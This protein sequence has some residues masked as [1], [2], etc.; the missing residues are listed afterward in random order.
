VICSR[1]NISHGCITQC[2]EALGY[3]SRFGLTIPFP[4]IV[5]RKP[6]AGGCGVCLLKKRVVSQRRTLRL[7]L[8]LG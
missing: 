8:G 3:V 1:K 7:N 2:G 5:S 4:E 6:K